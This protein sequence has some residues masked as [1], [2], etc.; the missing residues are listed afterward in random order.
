VWNLWWYLPLITL[1]FHS[2]RSCWFSYTNSSCVLHLC[3]FF[4]VCLLLFWSRFCIWERTCN[5]CVSQSGLFHLTFPFSANDIILFFFLTKPPL[6]T[7]TTFFYTSFDGHVG[8]FSILAFV[9]SAV[10]NMAVQ[11]SLLCA[12]LHSFRCVPKSGIAG[13][14]D[15][16][17]FSFVRSLHTDSHLLYHLSLQFCLF[18]FGYIPDVRKFVQFQGLEAWLK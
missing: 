17:I 7:Y 6:C 5:T 3:Q 2:P 18:F 10:I 9:N 15:T 11:V 1:S 16:S 12:D 13:L 14:H 8:W 4:F